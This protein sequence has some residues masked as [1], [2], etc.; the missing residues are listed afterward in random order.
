MAVAVAVACRSVEKREIQYLH[1]TPESCLQLHSLCHSP[2][3]I[4]LLMHFS[5]TNHLTRIVAVLSA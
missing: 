1:Y 5:D 2:P 4:L 3:S